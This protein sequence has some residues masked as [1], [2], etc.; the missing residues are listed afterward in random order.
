[1][2]FE[3]DILKQHHNWG[4]TFDVQGVTGEISIDNIQLV[5]EFIAR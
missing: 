1:M 5:K 4:P 3:L 2:I